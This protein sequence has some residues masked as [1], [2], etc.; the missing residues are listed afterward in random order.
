MRRGRSLEG[1]T[2][3]AVD[4]VLEPELTC[5][6]GDVAV[7]VRCEERDPDAFAMRLRG[8]QNV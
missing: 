7:L 1:A 6:F 4:A 2:G 8:S 5:E 3:W